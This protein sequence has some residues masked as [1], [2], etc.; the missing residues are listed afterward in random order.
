[1][2]TQFIERKSSTSLIQNLPNAAGV[3]VVNGDLYVHDGTAA[4]KVQDA[5]DAVAVGVAAGYKVARGQRT[6]LSALDTVVTG[7]ATVVAV[8]ASL[9]SDPTLTCDRASAA[10]G[11]QAGAPAAGSIYVKVWMPTATGDATPIAAT[12]FAAKI[13]NW[14]AWGT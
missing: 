11:T 10:I 2:S 1:M 6:M 14:V 9:E 4:R 13:V 8:T 12:G 7:L 5:A 3:A